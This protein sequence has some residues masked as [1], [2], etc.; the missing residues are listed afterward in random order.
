MILLRSAGPYVRALRLCWDTP[1]QL[2]GS[3]KRDVLVRRGV[4]EPRDQSEPRLADARSD[5]IEKGKLPNRRKDRA[6]VKELLHLVQYRLAFLAIELDCLLLV[7]RVDVGVAAINKRTAL[8]DVGLV[9]GRRV[10]EGAGT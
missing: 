9:A 4:G 7:E 8:D 6:L 5:P 3:L 10:A 2:S 1:Q